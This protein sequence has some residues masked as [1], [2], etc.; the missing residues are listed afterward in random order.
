[1]FLN[2]SCSSDSD[3]GNGTNTNSGLQEIKDAKQFYSSQG[4]TFKYRLYNYTP[5]EG[6]NSNYNNHLAEIYKI[7]ENNGVV[8]VI[9]KYIVWDIN[10][11]SY[12]AVLNCQ[13]DYNSPQTTNNVLFQTISANDDFEIDKNNTRLV[14]YNYSGGEHGSYGFSGLRIYVHNPVFFSGAISASSNQGYMFTINDRNFMLSMGLNSNYGHPMLYNYIP[15]NSSWSGN[16][17]SQMDWVQGVTTNLPTTNDAA[18]VGNSDKVFWA[19]L[20]FNTTPDNGKIN[21]ISYD[22]TNF[23]SVTS[24][25]GIGSV[26]TG[27]SMAYKHTIRL[28]KNPNSLGNPYMVVR[29]YNTDILDI[30]K[31]TGTAIEVVK[32][33]V[34][35]P[36]TIPITSGTTRSY[37]E[38]AFSGSNVYLITGSDENL[39]K[40]SGSTFVVDKQNLTQADDKITALEG[41]FEGVLISLEKTLAS[42]P[43]PKTVSDLVLIPN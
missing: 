22:G 34:S 21:I 32:T 14:S 10:L 41:T 16:S 29:R 12:G 3:S 13:G 15:T 42:S 7:I 31:F 33:G 1:L 23:S 40:L 35:L 28:Y 27:L 2:F 39:Y 24:L 26:G 43:K 25:T 9:A 19:W 30:Y 36:A 17:V 37:K 5:T 11:V 8:S 6:N 20:S 38:I 18:K 4:V